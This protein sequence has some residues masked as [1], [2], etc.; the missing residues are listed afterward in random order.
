MTPVT[1][2]VNAGAGQG[3]RGEW[4]AMLR[5]RFAAV[6]LEADVTLAGSG[7]EMIDVAREAVDDG[8]KVVVAGGGDGTLNAVAS[9]VVD[10]PAAFGVLPLG[11]LNHFARDLGV[12][13]ALDDAIA[14]IAHGRPMA[15]D[16]GE[17]NGRI[18]L[19]NSSL[20]LYP[21]IVRDRVKQQRRLGR[22]K[23]LAFCW[24]SL[25]ALH[26]FPFLSLRLHVHGSEHARR[27]PFV[28]IGN[29]AYT[30]EGFNIGERT[31]LDCGQLSLYMAQRPTRFG[32][33]RLA[34][35]ALAGRL[36]QARD[37]DMLLAEDLTIH[38]RR[39]LVRV[40]TDGEVSL[41]AP[42]L[43]YRSRPGALTVIVP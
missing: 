2:I 25:S 37:F 21:D 42:P 3:Y 18:F 30:M 8:A 31:R 19:N 33:V 38:T 1:V 32:L 11:T 27:T 24:A 7:Q 9:V 34:C 15:V 36:A 23:W 26:R 41:M 10:S 16:V 17:V 4:A 5:D 29:N 13:L 6:G 14:T 20:G 39:K 43:N 35:H 28:F 22:G 40:A 12:P